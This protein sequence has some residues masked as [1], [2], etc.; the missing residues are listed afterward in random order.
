MSCHDR[1]SNPQNISHALTSL[2][3]PVSLFFIVDAIE[4]NHN[5][6]SVISFRV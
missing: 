1:I 3:N 6:W 5:P 2:S 4:G